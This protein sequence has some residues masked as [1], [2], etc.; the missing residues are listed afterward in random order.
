M[1]EKTLIAKTCNNPNYLVIIISLTAGIL[2][3]ISRTKP[4]LHLAMMQLIYFPS[5]GTSNAILF[6]NITLYLKGTIL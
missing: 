2:T 4:T 6:F 3:L 5:A 1:S